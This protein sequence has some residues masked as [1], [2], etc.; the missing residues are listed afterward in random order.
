M[1]I[2]SLVPDGLSTIRPGYREAMH[3][4]GSLFEVVLNGCTRREESI[5]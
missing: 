5:A 2:N 4:V 1:R 3:R